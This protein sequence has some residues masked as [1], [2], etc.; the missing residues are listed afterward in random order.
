MIL[1]AAA[2]I[3]SFNFNSMNQLSLSLFCRSNSCYSTH[4]FLLFDNFHF[5]LITS[6]LSSAAAACF[7]VVSSSPSCY[8]FLRLNNNF[9][10]IR[11]EF[12]DKWSAIISYTWEWLWISIMINGRER[13]KNHTLTHLLSCIIILLA[14]FF[15]VKINLLAVKFFLQQTQNRAEKEMTINL[16]I[17]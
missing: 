15:F 8:L 2:V 6:H 14:L 4:R 13:E 1:A 7:W 5:A 11:V 16:F 3:R 9:I 10:E 12:V 17:W